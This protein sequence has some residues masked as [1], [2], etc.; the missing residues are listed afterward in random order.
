MSGRTPAGSL[1]DLEKR[2]A[3]EPPVSTPFVEYRFSRVLKRPASASGT[4]EYRADGV[5]VRDVEHP[6]RE[7]TTVSGDGVSVQRE[8]RAERRFPLERAP[9]LRVLLDS[10]RA[11]LDGRLSALRRDFTVSLEEAGRGWTITLSPL[12][13]TLARRLTTLRIDG[14][15]DRP[16]CLAI[17][18]TD[19]ASYTLLGPVTRVGGAPTRAELEAICRSPPAAP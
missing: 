10:F 7:R 5:L 19:G 11:L 18:M 17:A 16:T 6:Y 15:D 12:D 9:Q 2:L 4:L 8:G 13:A 14:T 1:E 3:R